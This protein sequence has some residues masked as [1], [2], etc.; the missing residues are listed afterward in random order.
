MRS[1]KDSI[2]LIDD[3]EENKSELHEILSDTYTVIDVNNITEALTKLE[4]HSHKISMILLDLM[5]SNMEGFTFL[6]ELQKREA[7]MNIPVIVIT[8]EYSELKEEEALQL[9]AYDIISKPFQPAIIRRRIENTIQSLKTAAVINL[10]ERDALT[11]LYSMNFFTEKVT[12]VLQ[13]CANEKYL[14]IFANISRFKLVN[15]LFGRT[16]GDEL[17]RF[18]GK[19]MIEMIGEHELCGH[20]GADNFFLF[21]KQECYSE[22]ILRAIVDRLNN[23]PIPINIVMRF[24]VYTLDDITMP[25]DKIFDRAK[26]AVDTFDGN[27][28]SYIC[29]YDDS[30][31]QKL[32]REQMITNAMKAAITEKQFIVFYQ[33]KFDLITE[34]VIGAEALVR[35]IHPEYGFLSPGEFIPIFEKNGFISELDYYVWEC[36]CQKIATWI[37]TGHEVIPISVNVSR[38]DLYNP[39]LP[40]L[41]YELVQRYKIPIQYLHLEITESAYTDNAKQMIEIVNEIRR[42]GFVIE[43]DDFGTGYSSLNMLSDLPI[44][45]LKLDMSFLRNNVGRSSGRSVIKFIINLA[46]WL[47]LFVVAEG[48]ETQ[49]QA[50]FLKNMGCDYAQ[51]Y[52]YSKPVA[53]V[54]FEKLLLET[55]I[56]VPN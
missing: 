30:I 34:S 8:S 7:I 2:L 3:N 49:D 53:E 6:S 17:L 47:G 56:N 36:V 44:E 41:L 31:R 46:K 5:I 26:L 16:E 22:A 48:V 4:N 51:G 14:V 39:K 24:G 9:G 28:D 23:Y 19:T 52:Y 45:I 37:E 40:K 20:A 55:R 25:I 33:P 43:M 11:G 54:D 29:Y 38:V 32:L 35:W 1:Q 42:Y 10:I 50:L 27:Y 13:T 18:I 15:E 12:E 21:M